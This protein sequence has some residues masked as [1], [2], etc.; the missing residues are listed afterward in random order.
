[1]GSGKRPST[2]GRDPLS[3]DL[4]S[5]PEPLGPRLGAASCGWASPARQVLL[6]G[7]RGTRLQAPRVGS[8]GRAPT[9][10]PAVTAPSRPHS[11][12]WLLDHSSSRPRLSCLGGGA[13]GWG[14]VSWP[15]SG[16]FWDR[17]GTGLPPYSRSPAKMLQF[18]LPVGASPLPS[19]SYQVAGQAQ[20]LQSDPCRVGPPGSL[21][22]GGHLPRESGSRHPGEDLPFDVELG[23]GSPGVLPLSPGLR[24]RPPLLLERMARIE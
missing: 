19:T 22:P 16:L 5:G 20:R 15:H 2:L 21:W 24:E 1:M 11:N 17:V 14:V 6:D 18:P 13:R 23:T 4:W 3:G 12:H 10:L 9:A 7:T 8:P